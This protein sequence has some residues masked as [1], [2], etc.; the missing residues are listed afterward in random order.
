MKCIIVLTTLLTILI[1]S[2]T[3]AA[4]QPATTGGETPQA[5][6]LQAGKLERQGQQAKAR[7]LYETLID[8][9]PASE[10][11]VKANDRLL[12]MLKGT[13]TEPPAKPVPAPAAEPKARA[14]ELLAMHKKA[15]DIADKEWRRLSYTFF[16]RYGHRVNR[17]ELREQ[18]AE[19]DKAAE[20]K[21]R[22]ELGMGSA[23]IKDKLDEACRELGI[24]GTC[25]ENALK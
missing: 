12:D 11:A 18:E 25:D 23:E 2:T 19:W 4:D 13:P 9:F 20:E 6:Y 16:N 5:I 1:A 14:R 7:D 21:V 10:F 22:K 8:R 15:L 3:L 17:G 24:A